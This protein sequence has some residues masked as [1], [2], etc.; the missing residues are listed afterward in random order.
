MYSLCRRHP[1]NIYTW[2]TLQE[3]TL[4]HMSCEIEDFVETNHLCKL[5]VMA[6]SRVLYSLNRAKPRLRKWHRVAP[7]TVLAVL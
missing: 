2:L 4:T 7:G 5:C 1:E 6:Q 3:N